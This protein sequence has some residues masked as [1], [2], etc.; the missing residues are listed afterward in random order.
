MMSDD[1]VDALVRAA[2]VSSQV[3]DDR[4]L[5][6]TVD[7]LRRIRELV[8]ASRTT[9]VVGVAGQSGTGRSSLVN[10]L[11]GRPVAEVSLVRPTTTHPTA[12]AVGSAAEVAATQLVGLPSVAAPAEASDG[13]VLIDLPAIAPVDVPAGSPDSVRPASVPMSAEMDQLDLVLW[14]TSPQRYSDL[15]HLLALEDLR[16][17]GATVEVVVTGSDTLSA[18]SATH[19]AAHLH[20]LVGGELLGGDLPL[21]RLVSSRSGAG[22]QELRDAIEG[23]RVSN[24]RVIPGL[25]FQLSTVA[26]RLR[27]APLAVLD[28]GGDDVPLSHLIPT[29]PVQQLLIE[30]LGVEETS[31]DLANRHCNTIAK[32]TAWPLLRWRS[33]LPTP[34]VSDGPDGLK[35]AA[36]LDDI[37]RTYGEVFGGSEPDDPAPGDPTSCDHASSE[38]VSSEPVSSEPVS[39]DPWSAALTDRIV[40]SAAPISATAQFARREERDQSSVQP[41]WSRRVHRLQ[42]LLLVGLIIATALAGWGAFAPQ[43][44]IEV[45]GLLLGPPRVAATATVAALFL[46]T[47]ILLHVVGRAIAAQERTRYAAHVKEELSRTVA[48][49]TD[50]VLHEATHDLLTA[51]RTVQRLVEQA[52]TTPDQ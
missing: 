19:I 15:D 42:D 46:L 13:L 22:I 12:Y 6:R 16:G 11:L 27:P 31:V 35:D 43:T 18:L 14:V 2:E 36:G 29:E 30:T 28:V 49:T 10:A 9:L 17:S 21:P 47:G 26:A 38:P 51:R 4:D 3:L 34:D 48:K 33:M 23:A 50:A 7:E 32:A 44:R 40:D 39:S 52:S 25:A 41:T 8:S 1:R 20:Q 5:A 45:L 24:R 37:L